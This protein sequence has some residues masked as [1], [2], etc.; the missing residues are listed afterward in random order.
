MSDLDNTIA[1]V[2]VKDGDGLTRSLVLTIDRFYMQEVFRK[3]GSESKSVTEILA[4]P[5]ILQ[6]IIRVEDKELMAFSYG[7][8][9][10]SGNVEEIAKIVSQ[11]GGVISKDYRTAISAILEAQRAN[12]PKETAFPCVGVFT[13]PWKDEL[14]IAIPQNHNIYQTNAREN[15]AANIITGQV[16]GFYFGYVLQ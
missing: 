8:V 13:D 11:T 2:I 4:R 12:V 16:Q 9:T 6:K 1:Q 3:I 15:G 10:G 5:I 14:A 7:E